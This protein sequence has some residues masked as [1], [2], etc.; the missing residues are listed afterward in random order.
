MTCTCQGREHLVC[1]PRFRATLPAR[2]AVLPR[3]RPGMDVR[4][5]VAAEIAKVGPAPAT[6]RYREPEA[7]AKRTLDPLAC[8]CKGRRHPV[9]LPARKWREWVT[10]AQ[11]FLDRETPPTWPDESDAQAAA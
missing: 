8:D 3:Y 4:A 2:K 5:F 10:A 1:S 7:D 6:F 11:A 9:C